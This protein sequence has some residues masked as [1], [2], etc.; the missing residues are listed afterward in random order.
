MI[1]TAALFLLLVASPSVVEG[2]GAPS[3]R[4][5]RLTE[6]I[7]IDGELTEPAWEAAARLTGF[8]QYQPVDGRPAA[9]PTEIRVFYTPEAIYFGVIAT[10]ADPGTVR[11]TLSKR[12]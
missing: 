9:E 8:S 12:D 11:A 1:V 2:R 3:V 7:R 6:A 5:P 10:A 4:P